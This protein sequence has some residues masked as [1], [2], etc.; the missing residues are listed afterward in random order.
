MLG[1]RRAPRMI[2]RCSARDGRDDVGVSEPSCLE[3]MGTI[4]SAKHQATRLGATT[5]AATISETRLMD[6][7]LD[8]LDGI[9]GGDGGGGYAPGSYEY[10][11]SDG[12]GAGL[13]NPSVQ[14]NASGFGVPRAS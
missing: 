3:G 14:L 4:M 6:V 12:T 2:R 11:A 5:V 1:P 10:P 7:E 9:S 13:P 8:E